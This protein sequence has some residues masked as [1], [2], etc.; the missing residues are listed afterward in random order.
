VEL[1]D[2]EDTA[3]QRV[4]PNPTRDEVNVVWPEEA[5][6]LSVQDASGRQLHRINGTQSGTVMLDVAA[7]PRGTVVLVWT[8]AAGEPC[9]TSRLV[10]E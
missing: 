5:K 7:W 2:P 1:L 4:F 8:G 6:S 3:A 9:G 10:L